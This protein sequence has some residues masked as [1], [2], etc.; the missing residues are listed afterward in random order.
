M[1]NRIAKVCAHCHKMIPENS[2]ESVTV[3]AVL[4]GS[5]SYF[6]YCRP[7]CFNEKMNEINRNATLMTHGLTSTKISK[8]TQLSEREFVVE[9]ELM[10][11]L[12]I[13]LAPMEKYMGDLT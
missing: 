12:N 11:A 13:V 8:V 9:L 1:L 6:Y 7:L 5:S 3:K 4:E 10:M 2:Q